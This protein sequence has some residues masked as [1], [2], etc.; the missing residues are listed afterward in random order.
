VQK[1]HNH[2]L[3]PEQKYFFQ[4]EFFINKFKQVIRLTSILCKPTIL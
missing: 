1:I 4:H 2:L 3:Q